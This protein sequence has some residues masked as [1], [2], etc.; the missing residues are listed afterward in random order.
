MNREISEYKVVLVSLS[1][2]KGMAQIW[3][4]TKKEKKNFCQFQTL[5]VHDQGSTSSLEDEC[6]LAVSMTRE[7]FDMPSSY[8]DCSPMGL[9]PHPKILLGLHCFFTGRYSNAVILRVKALTHKF[10]GDANIPFIIGL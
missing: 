8:K 5:T 9:G 4:K 7:S 2:N 6:L 1:C 10:G 3:C